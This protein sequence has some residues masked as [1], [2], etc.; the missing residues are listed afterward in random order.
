MF[1]GGS[2]FTVL[3]LSLAFGLPTSHAL[4]VRQDGVKMSLT[5]RLQQTTAKNII[6][7]DIA[8][9]KRF[10]QVRGS[11][12]GI[13]EQ[14]EPHG[15]TY[16]ATVGVGN[17]PTDYTLIVDTGSSNI[18]IG[19]NKSYIPTKSSFP[20]P[21]TVEEVYGS[22]TFSGNEFLD[23]VTLADG[24]VLTNQSIGVANSTV[25]SFNGGDGLLG[26]GQAK[27]T[28]GTLHPDINATIPTVTDTSY[29]EGLIPS[30]SVGVFLRPPTADNPGIGELTFGGVDKTKLTSE[31]QYAPVPQ[32]TDGLI[33]NYWSVEQSVTYGNDNVPILNA[34]TGL[35]D[36]GTTFLFLSSDAYARYVEATGAVLDPAVGLLTVNSTQIDSLQSLYFNING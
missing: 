24:L 32:T 30:H 13:N 33:G 11:E 28:R 2:F 26:L 1:L 21:N 20:T 29:A 4:V 10:T 18:W 36:S 23:Q 12:S 6:Q 19:A 5:R 25:G 14:V 34:T 22:G 35:V 7:Q 27:L 15:F 31:I 8:R 3:L 9:L 16:M 17:P